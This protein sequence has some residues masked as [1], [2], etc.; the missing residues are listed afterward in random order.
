MGFLNQ[1]KTKWILGAVAALLAV[2]VGCGTVATRWVKN[3]DLA[4][5]RHPQTGILLGAEEEDLGPVD[6]PGAVLFVHGFVGGGSNFA[7]LPRR[8]AEQGWRVRVMRLPG[9][10][11]SPLDFEKVKPAELIEAVTREI[12]RLRQRY[13]YVAVVA[14]SM[15]GALAVIAATNVKIDRLVLAAP[16]FG[17]SYKWYY[18]LPPEAW[19]TLISP[20]IRWVKKGDRFVMVNR[21]E[22][23][24]EIMSYRWIPTQGIR[25]LITL[26]RMARD[27]QRLQEL[28]CPVLVI[29]STGDDAASPRASR[30]AFDRIA[31]LEK[32]WLGLTQ[33]NHHVFFDYEREQVAEAV[34]RFL[35]PPPHADANGPTPP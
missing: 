6:A 16:Y 18:L 34:L 1:I 10:G 33:S 11:T 19:S 7:D 23:K 30:Q 24:S 35:G 12:T 29:Q 25:T 27:P 8:T 15:G 22:A 2:M 3:A 9:H 14:H 21:K 26:G 32:Q 17:V 28:T 31:S 4:A 13:P 5:P 20:F